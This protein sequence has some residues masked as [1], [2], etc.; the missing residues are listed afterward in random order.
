MSTFCRPWTEGKP[1]LTSVVVIE[2]YDE[3]ELLR[4]AGSL[5]RSSEHPLAEAIVDGAEQRG[6]TLVSAEAFQ[7]FT[8]MGVA[9]TIE[10]RSVAL[11]NDKLLAEIG[12]GGGKLEDHAEKT[13]AG[14]RDRDVRRRGRASRR[15]HRRRRPDSRNLRRKPSAS[16][17]RTVSGS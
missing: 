16:Y 11:G 14:R 12:A 15:S 2:D 10:G 4:L 17:E 13:S 5:E 3:K 7:S 6:L 9:G 1:R 8:G